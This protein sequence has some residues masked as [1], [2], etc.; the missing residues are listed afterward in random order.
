[1]ALQGVVGVAIVGFAR[2][3]A[4]LQHPAL[5][6]VHQPPPQTPLLALRELMRDLCVVKIVRH[7]PN[8]RRAPQPP[9]PSLKPLGYKCP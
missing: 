2:C 5:G 7:H 8:Q 6:G 9:M 3:L 4:T 1:M